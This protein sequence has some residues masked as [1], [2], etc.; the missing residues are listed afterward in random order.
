[1]TW[2]MSRV[3]HGRFSLFVLLTEQPVQSIALRKRLV[4]KLMESL[5]GVR[6]MLGVPEMEDAG[7]ER[8]L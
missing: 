6:K 7:R 4:E 1:M 5:A 2:V 3:R 8:E